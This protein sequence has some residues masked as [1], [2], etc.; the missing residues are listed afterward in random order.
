MKIDNLTLRSRLLIGFVPLLLVL[1]VNTVWAASMAEGSARYWIGAFG[2]VAVVFGAV[3]AWWLVRSVAAPVR[4]ALDA[5]R[6]IMAG[7]LT[8]PITHTRQ[9]EFG[10]LMQALH[11]LKDCLFKVVSDVRTGTTT[12]ASTSSQINRDNTSLSERTTTQT[13]SLQ[14][15]AAS[16]EQITITVKHNADNAEQANKLVLEASGHA[17]K[18]GEVVSQVVTTMGSIKE[19]SRRI[20]DIIGVIDGIAFQTNILALNAAVEAAR[21]GEQGRGFAV[22]AAE[23]RT[24]AQRSATAAKE[25]K[26]LIGDSVDKVETGSRLVDDAGRAMTEIVSSVKHV[27]GLMQEMAGSSHEQSQGIQSV[28]QAIAEVDGMVQQNAKLVKDATQTAATLNEQ[29][30]GLLKSVAGYNLGTREHGSAE[31][32]E[33]LVKAGLAFYKAHGRDALIAEINKLGKGQFIDRDLYLMAITI[34]DYKFCAHGNNPRTLGAG[35]VSKDVDGKF[36]VKEMAELA[37]NGGQ[38]WVDYKWAHPV[39]NEIRLKSSYVERAGDLAVAC[40]I[41]KG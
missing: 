18:G 11:G 39:T 41:Y 17:V 19:S 22:V 9:D 7:D 24:L 5:A 8:L 28:N 40:G 10:Q 26:S 21:A 13:D 33:A 14:Q 3:L 4:E 27:A 6:Q 32:A 34:D 25:I 38:A 2:A 29:A 23:V 20:A 16:M 31:E 15:T 1:A 35:P 36:F 12:V 37:R 30:V